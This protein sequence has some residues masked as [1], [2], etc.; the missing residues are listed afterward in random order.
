MTQGIRIGGTTLGQGL[1]RVIATGVT[2]T[3]AGSVTVADFDSSGKS[4]I[5]SNEAG[6]GVRS[7][8]TSTVNS[9]TALF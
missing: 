3:S 7:G 9:I 4:Y 2:G 5:I 1:Q 8:G 6:L